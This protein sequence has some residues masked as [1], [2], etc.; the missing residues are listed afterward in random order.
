MNN[1]W[2]EFEKPQS[3]HTMH[4]DRRVHVADQVYHQEIVTGFRGLLY[5]FFQ[6]R[7]FSVFVSSIYSYMGI[8]KA[9]SH[10]GK[11]LA[12]GSAWPYSII[13][14]SSSLSAKY[15]Q[16]GKNDAAGFCILIY[17]PWWGHAYPWESATTDWVPY[18]S[19]QNGTEFPCW[20][21][22]CLLSQALI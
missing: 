8:S 13:F 12:V 4:S 9:A 3:P 22:L 5:I 20:T 6:D 10:Q 14:K 11:D 16:C 18:F 21:H 2:R 19:Q 1:L 15:C 17:S 7:C